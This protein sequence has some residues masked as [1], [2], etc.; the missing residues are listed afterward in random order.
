M[1]PPWPPHIPFP[2][3]NIP[4]GVLCAAA[5]HHTSFLRAHLATRP[6][7]P[8]PA[9]APAP[10]TDALGSDTDDLAQPKAGPGLHRA[11]SLPH[12]DAE[13]LDALRTEILLVEDL[14]L[15]LRD[16]GLS[17]VGLK[18]GLVGR[19]FE[20]LLTPSA[21]PPTPRPSGEAPSARFIVDSV[22]LQT[23]A[24]ALTS[25]LAAHLSEYPRLVS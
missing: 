10:A 25:R 6:G 3:A 13:L 21:S 18:G 12:P 14:R 7:G 15:H 5:T 9:L 8:P 16:R 4:A 23:S 22:A 11:A 2:S 1:V 20:Y 17:S 19:L 24:P